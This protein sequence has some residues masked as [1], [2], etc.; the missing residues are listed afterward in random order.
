MEKCKICS[1]E[2]YLDQHDNVIC[3]NCNGFNP[4]SKSESLEICKKLTQFI[5]NKMDLMCN[6]FSYDY[7]MKLGFGF[8]EHIPI[9]TT[10]NL[11]E[12]R[13]DQIIEGTLFIKNVLKGHH[14]PD[15]KYFKPFVELMGINLNDLSSL[16]QYIIFIQ[17]DY[18]NL[19]ECSKYL[20]DKYGFKCIFLNENKK[21]YTF[22]PKISWL[23]YKNSLKEYYISSKSRLNEIN[24]KISSDKNNEPKGEEN[25]EKRVYK[26]LRGMYFALYY[27]SLDPKIFSFDEIDN[28]PEV[29]LFIKDLFILSQEIISRSGKSFA[30]I[31]KELFFKVAR[32]YDYNSYKLF[33]MFVSSKTDIKEFPILI[34]H[35]NKLI[36]SPS[37][38]LLVWGF[39]EYKFNP[40]KVNSLLTGHDFEDEIEKKLIEL[41][42][43]LKDPKNPQISLK[44]RKVKTKNGEKQIDLI[45]YNKE[46][47]WVIECKD[48][49]LWKIDPQ[50]MWKNRKKYR[51]RDIK[52]EI[53]NKHID[54]VQF[55]K[56]N[57]E[58]YFGFKND[59]KI[60]GLLVTRIKED[61]EEYNGVKIVSGFELENSNELIEE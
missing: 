35:N 39:L 51:I 41:G 17:E 34:E 44:G 49:G 27:V 42:L 54:R 4:L 18:G 6:E 60:K 45:A 8:R 56:D 25:L 2:L 10:E 47:I 55:V 12:I 32:N 36:L 14:G 13:I 1:S 58:T 59:Y 24:K 20:I 61:I 33:K 53:N 48:H 30:N 29:L 26:T 50:I 22:I 37:T 23:N 3:P 19:F 38:I 11:T 21:Y 52:M 28:N 40:E 46:V 57:Y 9:Q 43:S 15:G 5:E 31:S 7:L 16:R